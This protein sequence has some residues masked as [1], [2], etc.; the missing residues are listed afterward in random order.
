MDLDHL[1]GGLARTTLKLVWERLGGTDPV[2]PAPPQGPAPT[3]PVPFDLDRR[4]LPPGESVD[5]LLPRAAG[6][7]SRIRVHDRFGGPRAGGVLG[8]YQAGS[9]AVRVLAAAAS[10]PEAARRLVAQC[11]AGEREAGVP[12]A[13]AESLDT[14]PSY[15]GA[16]GSFIWSRGPYVFCA[17][18]HDTEGDV[19]L[20]ATPAQVAVLGRFLAAFPY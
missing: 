17:S 6:E 11:R 20:P 3:G 14:E 8:L 12:P 18:S 9:A 16:P 5:A 7:F 4:P 10:S 2:G 15:S 13:V 19:A 1:L